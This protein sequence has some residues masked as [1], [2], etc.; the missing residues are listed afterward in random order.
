L[1]LW[2]LAWFGR[3]AAGDTAKDVFEGSPVARPECE[4]DRLVL[5]KLEPLGI[6]PA[7]CS[8]EVFLRRVYLDATGA[9]PTAAEARAFLEDPDRDH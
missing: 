2:S 4:I 5:A 6:R 8:D 9:L 3:T 1:A 7:V